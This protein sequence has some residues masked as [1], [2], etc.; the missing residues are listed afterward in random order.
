M[1]IVIVVALSRGVACFSIG[2]VFSK[3][4]DKPRLNSHCLRDF[5]KINL[6]CTL[7]ILAMEAMALVK[8]QAG[9]LNEIRACARKIL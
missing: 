7:S 4:K 6:H 2:R 9:H 1:V 5:R 3:L 8:V